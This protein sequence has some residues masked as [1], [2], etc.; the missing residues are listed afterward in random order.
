MRRLLANPYALDPD[1][2]APRPPAPDDRAIG[3][4][5]PLRMFTVPF[6]MA[7]VNT[8]VVR[9][10]HALA[11]FPWG[12]DFVY[13]EVMS[14]PGSARGAV[15]VAAVAGALGGLALALKYRRLRELLA[16]RAP[17]PGEGPSADRREHGH[18]KVR[19][20]GEAAATARRTGWSTW[21]RTART[22]AT[23][24]PRRCSASR[25]SA[26]RWIR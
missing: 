17:Q 22:R 12:E 5:R 19:F 25:R 9:R 1:P 6:V 3:W 24:R 15:M 21:R 23:A 16:R 4:N 18:W 13:R 10:A 8:R 7:A 26:S 20:L 14:T 2:D 11:G